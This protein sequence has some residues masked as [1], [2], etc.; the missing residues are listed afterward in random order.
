[1]SEY[2]FTISLRIRHPSIEPLAI[3]KTL[4][5]EPQHTW[6]AG[7]ARRSPAGEALDGTYR[8]SYWM[9]RLMPEPELSSSRSSVESVLLQT[10]AQLRRSHAFLEQLGTAGGVAELHVSL[11]AREDFRLDLSAE[12]LVTLGRLGLAVAL[13]IHPHAPHGGNPSSA[14]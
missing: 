1:M 6:K 10:L 11:F 4:G 9:A 12:T 8:E 5:I 2:E 13:E 14:N 7:D 3:T